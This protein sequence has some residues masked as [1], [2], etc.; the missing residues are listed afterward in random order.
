[1]QAEGEVM[2]AREVAEEEVKNEG[3]RRARKQPSLDIGLK[4]AENYQFRFWKWRD[5]TVQIYLRRRE[6]L[7]AAEIRWDTGK[8]QKYCPYLWWPWCSDGHICALGDV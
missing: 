8:Y 7:S 3:D 6:Y 2:S 4:Y 5:D 1:M